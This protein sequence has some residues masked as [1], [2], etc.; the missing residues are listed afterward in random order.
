MNALFKDRF[1]LKGEMTVQDGRGKKK[2]KHQVQW[3]IY[4]FLPYL[5]IAMHIR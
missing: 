3:N 2:I 4:N 5:P 1:R